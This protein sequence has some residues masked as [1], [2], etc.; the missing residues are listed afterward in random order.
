MVEPDC[1]LIVEAVG[2]DYDALVV[3]AQNKAAAFLGPD[4]AYWL[5]IGPVHMDEATDGWRGEAHIVYP[6]DP[7]F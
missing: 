5:R 3:D 7:A 2:R 1:T 6:H 4:R